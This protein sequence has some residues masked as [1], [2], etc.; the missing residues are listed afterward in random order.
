MPQTLAVV[1]TGYIQHRFIHLKM[2]HV[3]YNAEYETTIPERVDCK[4]NNDD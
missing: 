4:K 3:W 2:Q 1:Y